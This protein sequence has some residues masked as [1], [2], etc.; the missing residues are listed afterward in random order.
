MYVDGSV[1]YSNE[2][3]TQGDPFAMP[4]YALATLPLSMI[5]KLSKSATQVWHADDASTCGRLSD[6]RLWWDQISQLCPP[7][8]YFPNAK[9]TW[10]VVKPQYVELACS[11]FADCRVNATADGKP[12]LGA[13]VG[14]P[15]Y[16]CWGLCFQ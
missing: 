6:L 9:K 5:G 4:F 15:S 16:V 11:L 8:G 2:G 3:T 14:S 1:L 10:L 13:A 12:Y 7:F